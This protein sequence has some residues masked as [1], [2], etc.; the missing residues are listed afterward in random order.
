MQTSCIFR[1]RIFPRA[2]LRVIPN[3]A[4]AKFGGGGSNDN[5]YNALIG[6]QVM[7]KNLS[8]TAID[9]TSAFEAIPLVGSYKIDAEGVSAKEKIPLIE[10]GM[11]KALL[12]DRVPAHGVSHSTGHKRLVWLGDLQPRLAPGVIEMTA[13]KTA[14]AAQMKK[15]LIET[16]KKNG[17]EY[18]YIVRKIGMPASV[19]F[20]AMM[21]GKDPVEKPAY[22]YRVSVKDGTETLVRTAT[23][24]KITI[25]SFKEVLAVSDKKQ[26]W[27]LPLAGI[28]RMFQGRESGVH[29]SFIV[30]KGILL[31]GIELKKNDDVSL[32]KAPVTPNPVK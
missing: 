26:A 28:S 10:N 27:N 22:V 4:I 23:I 3:V 16:A 29:A 11:L 12:S 7:N 8:V 5:K 21:S 17:D 18:A 15:Q 14:S 30:P 24:S 9:K 31:P 2:L 6:K 20:S 32:Q 19:D 1:R 25:D 13:K